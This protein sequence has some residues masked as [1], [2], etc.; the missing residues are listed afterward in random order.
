MERYDEEEEKAKEEYQKHK[1]KGC[2][3][4]RWQT[5]YIVSCLFP[6]CMKDS[7][8]FMVDKLSVKLVFALR[9]EVY[10]EEAPV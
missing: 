2:V 4:A 3:W 7:S 1:C 9:I 10:N 5:P 8:R 6:R